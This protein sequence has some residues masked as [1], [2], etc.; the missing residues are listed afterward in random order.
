LFLLGIL[1]F[2][3]RGKLD[4]GHTFLK[5]TILPAKHS[6]CVAFDERVARQPTLL[7]SLS[8]QQKHYCEALTNGKVVLKNTK[9]HSQKFHVYMKLSEALTNLSCI[10]PIKT[11]SKKSFLVRKATKHKINF[12]VLATLRFLN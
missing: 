8:Y 11:S 12:T 2:P 6:P 10:D 9:A 7:S 5:H 4:G 1:P 3:L